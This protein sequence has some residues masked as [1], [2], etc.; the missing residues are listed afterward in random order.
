[1]KSAADAI[2]NPELIVRYL[3]GEPLSETEQA[4]IERRLFGNDEFLEEIQATELQL[5]ARYLQND[6]SP[7][8][9]ELFE[10]HFL[11]S[12]ERRNA[13]E[14][15]RGLSN[16]LHSGGKS[17]EAESEIHETSLNG[18]RYFPWMPNRDVQRAHGIGFMLEVDTNQIVEGGCYNPSPSRPS[19]PRPPDMNPLSR[20]WLV[21][22]ILGLVAAL[23]LVFFQQFSKH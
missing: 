22:I 1:M 7:R 19:D 16:A 8:E 15:V 9:R 4:E 10:N 3:L 11:L 6:L 20:R 2:L 18:S 12:Q 21:V 5:M 23:A 17:H 13:L 14:F